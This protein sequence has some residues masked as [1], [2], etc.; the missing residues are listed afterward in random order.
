MGIMFIALKNII[1]KMGQFALRVTDNELFI[2]VELL[3]ISEKFLKGNLNKAKEIK[4]VKIWKYYLYW[5]S[6]HMFLTPTFLCLFT[7]S[8]VIP[9]C[10][11]S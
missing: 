11:C 3:L 10:V 4:N 8:P 7:C 5:N 6:F 9:E 2:T 1:E